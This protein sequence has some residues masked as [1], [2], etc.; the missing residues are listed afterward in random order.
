V[1]QDNASND[2]EYFG[3]NPPDASSYLH[4]TDQPIFNRPSLLAD[5][6]KDSPLYLDVNPNR[7]VSPAWVSQYIN[8]GAIMP[9]NSEA[10]VMEYYLKSTQKKNC[11]HL[12]F[13]PSP[14]IATV[15]TKKIKKGEELFTSYGCVF[16]IGLLFNGQEGAS[17]TGQIQQQIRESAQD[18]FTAMKGVSTR[19]SNQIE[20]LHSVFDDIAV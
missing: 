1:S 17:M 2:R 19:Y 9:E 16:W 8:D 18:L 3:V 11:I 10:G 5:Q 14:I 20:A 15:A 12:P 13:G 7:E 4:A 6:M